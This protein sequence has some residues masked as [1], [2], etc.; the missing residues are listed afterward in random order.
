VESLILLRPTTPLPAPIFSPSAASS[1]F[2]T[3]PFCAASVDDDDDDDDDDNNNDKDIVFRGN[4]W[5]PSAFCFVTCRAI[6]MHGDSPL[7]V[8]DGTLSVLTLFT[9]VRVDCKP[10]GLSLGLEDA[11]CFRAIQSINRWGGVH[12]MASASA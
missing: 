2:S 1:T 3:P 12:L 6:L 4:D 8:V 10:W 5:P 7:V 9:S 11:T